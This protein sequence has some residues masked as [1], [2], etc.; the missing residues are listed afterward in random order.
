M[1]HDNTTSI[2]NH[3]LL[4][5][6]RAVGRKGRLR[7]LFPPDRLRRI[8]RRN[9]AASLVSFGD[10]EVEQRPDGFYWELGHGAMGMTYLALDKV[11]RRRV[12]LKVIE[13][14]ADREQLTSHTRTLFT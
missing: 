13:V 5:M 10:F 7:S 14:P 8:S 4:G 12:A 11:L 2:S 3:G 9:Q 6:R 1:R